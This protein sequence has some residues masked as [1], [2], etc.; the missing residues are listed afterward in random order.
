MYMLGL[1][2]IFFMFLIAGSLG[3]L[4]FTGIFGMFFNSSKY[5]DNYSGPSKYIDNS[6]HHHYHDNRVAYLDG[7]KF[8]PN[9]DKSSSDI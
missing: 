2:I 7:D 3:Y 8:I 9:R 6:V 1:L 5:D 4:L